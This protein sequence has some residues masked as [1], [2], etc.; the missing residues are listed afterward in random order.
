MQSHEVMSVIITLFLIVGSP[1]FFPHCFYGLPAS[2]TIGT[3]SFPRVKRPSDK[4]LEKS[5][6]IPLLCLRVFV[7]YKKGETPPIFMDLLQ[8]LE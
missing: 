8:L 3:G 6:A 4:V 2:C 1:I 5:R 7:A